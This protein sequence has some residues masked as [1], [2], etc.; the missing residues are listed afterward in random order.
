MVVQPL[1]GQMCRCPPGTEVRDVEASAG[2]TP[3][4]YLFSLLVPCALVRNETNKLV[5]SKNNGTK[6][7]IVLFQLIFCHSLPFIGLEPIKSQLS[8]S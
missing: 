7:K 2:Q 8:S 4:L 3:V 5:H 1:R 6:V